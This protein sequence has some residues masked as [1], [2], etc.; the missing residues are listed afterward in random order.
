MKPMELTE[1]T[2]HL[3]KLTTYPYALLCDCMDHI[4]RAV[5]HEA[6][7]CK[8]VV[9]TSDFDLLYE[10]LFRWGYICKML[11]ATGDYC[12]VEIYLDPWHYIYEKYGIAYRENT[13]EFLNEANLRLTKEQM[14]K[15][16]SEIYDKMDVLYK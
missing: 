16:M 1:L 14:I 2:K 9:K 8:Y 11:A 7:T 10:L 13:A 4:A 5:E 15:M 3:N 6:N 12:E